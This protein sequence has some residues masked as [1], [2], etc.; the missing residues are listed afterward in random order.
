[1]SSTPESAE[2]TVSSPETWVDVHGDA[3]YRYALIHLRDPHWAEEAVQET[4]LAALEARH[5][6]SGKGTERTWLIG[7]LK[8]KL[9]D[10]FRRHAR[11]QFLEADSTSADENESIDDLFQ[12]DGHWDPPLR[13]WGN[14]DKALENRRFWDAL[15]KCLNAMPPKLARLFSLREIAGLDSEEICKELRVTTTNL[16]TM[17]HR[18]RTSLR[19]CLER[20]WLG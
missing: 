14:P 1:M 8:H 4:L 5:N 16:W 13:D 6:F 2:T 15:E 17:L 20:N 12:P 19:H 3:L 9:I 10:Q 18:S 7:I 11:E